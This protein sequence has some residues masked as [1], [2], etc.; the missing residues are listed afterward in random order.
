MISWGDFSIAIIP[1]LSDN[2]V[3]AI[4][5]ASLRETWLIDGGDAPPI[6]EWARTTQAKVTNIL[7]THHHHDHVDGIPALKKAFNAKV[8]SS[9]FD[10]AR[11]LSVD[12]GLQDE[13]IFS[14][15]GLKAHALMIP[16]HTLGHMAIYLPEPGWLFTGDTWFGLGCGRL[17]E[18]TIEQLKA[19]LDRLQLLPGATQIFCGHEYTLRNSD[20]ALS[21]EPSNSLL[22]NRQMTCSRLQNIGQPTVPF[23]IAEELATNPF[24]RTGSAEI[25]QNLHLKDATDLDVFRELRHRR[26][27]YS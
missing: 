15:L 18:G 5:S 13:Q 12:H 2:Y 8:W 23:T 26:N 20:F 10:Q 22:K 4:S 14:L 19:A 21:V 27:N 7:A 16:G 24:L 6:L 1:V 17:F 11:I 25:R 3:Y 9:Q